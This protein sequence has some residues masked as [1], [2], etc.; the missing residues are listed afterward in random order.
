M[1]RYKKQRIT[2]SIKT[3][4]V[5]RQGLKEN[6]KQWLRRTPGM[7]IRE[8]GN[9]KPTYCSFHSNIDLPFLSPPS[10]E[11]STHRRSTQNSQHIQVDSPSQ[12]LEF[13]PSKFLPNK[14]K[15]HRHAAS[16]DRMRSLSC[17]LCY[18]WIIQVPRVSTHH[19]HT[20]IPI[21][22]RYYVFRSTNNMNLP[23]NQR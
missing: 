15:V 8:T 14:T 1:Q 13:F 5:E 19:T 22:Q 21:N 12:T 2:F 23:H 16:L 20:C 17:P 4:G 3:R 11:I 9:S 6:L 7:E 18:L 10:Q